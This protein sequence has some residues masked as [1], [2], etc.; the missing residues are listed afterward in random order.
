[1]RL[2]RRF[3]TVGFHRE[4]GRAMM[5]IKIAWW[6]LRWLE[7]RA[8]LARAMGMAAMRWGHNWGDGLSTRFLVAMTNLVLMGGARLEIDATT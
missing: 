8:R 3:K 1:M 2:P 6:Y 5:D 4:G 7:F